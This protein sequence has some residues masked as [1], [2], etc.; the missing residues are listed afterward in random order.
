MVRMLNLKNLL[1]YIQ[2][3]WHLCV[4]LCLCVAVC[5]SVSVVFIF[6]DVSGRGYLNQ[7]GTAL[8]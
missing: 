7:L 4:Y 3:E 6:L 2:C 1:F 8:Q 5:V